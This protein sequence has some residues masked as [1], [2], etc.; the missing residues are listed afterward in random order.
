MPRSNRR[1]NSRSRSRSP[2]A[3]GGSRDRSRSGSRSKR[4]DYRSSKYDDKESRSNGKNSSGNDYNI[5][6]LHIAD[7]TDKCSQEDLEKAFSKYGDIEE[8]WLARNPPCFAFVVYKKKEDAE[9]ALSKMD[10]RTIA[11]ARIR[12]TIARPRVKRR[13]EAP[14]RRYD[15]PKRYNNYGGRN[16]NYSRDSRDRR[17][18]R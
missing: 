9:Q 1:S 7:L 11:G 3:R 18:S 10:G 14:R 13:T 17:R 4:D 8:V 12:V 5:C 2:A 16:G 15:A 6:R